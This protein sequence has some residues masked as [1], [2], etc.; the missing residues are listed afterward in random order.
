MKKS[1]ASRKLSESQAAEALRLK[2]LAAVLASASLLAITAQPVFAQSNDKADQLER[3]VVTAT[4]QAKTKMRSSV[5]VT[6]IDGETLKDFNP[7]SE[8]Q[9][10]LLI[11]GIR[12]DAQNLAGGNSN[13]SVR[14]LP[15]ASGG[16]KFVQLQED[17]LATVQFG[18]MNFSN[19]DYWIRYD[20]NVDRI[21]ALR[22][23]SASTFASHAP[24]AV[25][26]YIS[27]TG[28]EQ[29]GSIGLG[30]GLN[31]KEYKLDGEYGG[32][33][34]SDQYY[35]IGGYF[36]MGEGPR[37]TTANSLKGYQIKGNFTQEFNSGKGYIRAYVKL[38]D[39]HAPTTA[40]TF[41]GSSSF[42]PG[43]GSQY[44]QYNSSVPGVDIVTRAAK[45]TSL[46]DGISVN[47][48]S[49][50]FEFHNE[51][52]GGFLLDNK[53]RVSQNSGAFNA[54]FWNVRTFADLMGDSFNGAKPTKGVYLNGP[55]AGQTVAGTTLV[56]NGAAI[57]TQTP[58]MGNTIN[59]LSFGKA[60]KFD[61]GSAE[62]KGGFYYSKQ[63]VVQRWS[64]SERVVEA[65]Q[66]GAVI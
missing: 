20:I 35:H 50:G 60:F 4:T 11:P 14:G 61:G 40:Q 21:Q 23:G 22:G 52:N 26:N 62:V 46:T 55:M 25:I 8:S 45:T 17:G 10:L 51:F 13:I 19:N 18:D 59:D 29:G 3:V 1:K 53:F 64:I 30:M 66:N 34:G 42:D 39:E 33:L 9:A 16:A 58:D 24:G 2:P 27:K 56:S 15:I 43:R 5:S 57:D 63:N 36:R 48:K 37:D 31:Y 49:L 7:Q 12:T 32:K 38:L 41:T 65:K 54:Q 28:K 47:S 6:D 44:S